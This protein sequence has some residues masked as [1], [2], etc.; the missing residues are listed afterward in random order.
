M[1]T[2]PWYAALPEGGPGPSVRW[3]SPQFESELRAWVDAALAPLGRRVLTL[4][5]VH[6]RPWST[7]WR[8]R[9]DD[10]T[11][12]WA[13]QNCPHQSFEA[14]LLVVLDRIAG[15]R[16]VPVSA[17]DVERGLHLVADQG[18]VLAETVADDDVEAWCRV[19]VEAMHL[20]RELVGHDAE[21]EAAGLRRMKTTDAPEYVAARAEALSSLPHD[22][23]RRMPRGDADGIRALDPM[24]RRW[25][26]QLE[27]LGLPD[28]LV[29]NDLHVH[30]VFATG[31][32]LRFFDFGD[33][34]LAN[35]LWA[36][37]VP[38]RVMSSRLELAP[39]DRRLR[40]VS[41]AA[42]EVWSDVVS[43]GELRA[44]LPA[45]LQLARLGRVE[46]WL[47][48]TATLTPAELADLG[49]AATWW[50]GSLREEPLLR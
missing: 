27:S 37:L 50:L 28:S 38:L 11:D 40:R 8:A 39:D 24:V 9:A 14:H 5:P 23:P 20:Q 17:A 15:D 19:V 35:P 18:P 16:V 49:D 46:S 13:K 30:N 43:T 25:A 36:L 10:G 44:A 1:G 42:L 31:G 2:E 3:T 4:E 41:D 45:A 6:Q 48:V 26:A 12:Y 7:V 21:L 33:A 47:R 29:H 32:T 22:D 34:V